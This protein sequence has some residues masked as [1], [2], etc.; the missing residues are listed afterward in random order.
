MASPAASAAATIKGAAQHITRTTAASGYIDFFKYIDYYRSTMPNQAVGTR[1]PSLD[2]SDPEVVARFFHGLADP[3]RVQILQ[4]LLDGPKTAGEI[5]GHVGR[6][7][8]SVSS[9]LTCLRFCGFVEA[10]RVGR[11]VVYELVDPQTRRLLEMGER[12]LVKNAERIMACRVIAPS[13]A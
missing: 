12:Y 13:E 8:P 2:P 9:H 6:Y 1:R 11:T 7:Q 10:R 3:T 4:F 5:V